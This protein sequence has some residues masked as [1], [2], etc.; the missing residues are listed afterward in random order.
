VPPR[1]HPG[2]TNSGSSRSPASRHGS[3][4]SCPPGTTGADCRPT[5]TPPANGLD[6]TLQLAGSRGLPEED[7]PTRRHRPPPLSGS[8]RGSVGAGS[9][10]HE[11]WRSLPP[12]RPSP[13]PGTRVTS[14]WDTPTAKATVE[15]LVVNR[16]PWP[17]PDPP[18]LITLQLGEPQALRSRQPAPPSTLPAAAS[19]QLGFGQAQLA[20]PAG[21]VSAL[22]PTARGSRRKQPFGPR[23]DAPAISRS[24]LVAALLV[25]SNRLERPRPRSA[26]STAAEN[27]ACSASTGWPGWVRVLIRGP[28]E[29]RHG[30]PVKRNLPHN[31]PRIQ[32]L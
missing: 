16:K 7:R 11:P 8:R 22:S 14:P 9:S 20:Q 27:K 4:E 12:S 19:H 10:T 24:A 32:R 18:V 15:Q 26:G 30:Q 25:A 2:L 31:C 28:T 3:R 13:P 23:A 21:D 6:P 17:A 5:S 29:T 1:P